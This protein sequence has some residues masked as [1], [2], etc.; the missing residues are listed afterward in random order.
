MRSRKW[1][2]SGMS[3]RN[4]VVSVNIGKKTCVRLKSSCRIHAFLNVGKN[5]WIH[6]ES[7]RKLI[8]GNLLTFNL[9]ISKTTSRESFEATVS[10]LSN[11]KF[12]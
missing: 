6:I 2:W 5:E 8:P 1:F 9:S 10:E 4:E 3:L 7:N 11:L 12:P